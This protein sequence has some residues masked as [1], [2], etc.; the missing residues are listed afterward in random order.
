M[1]NLALAPVWCGLHINDGGISA[2][3]NLQPTSTKHSGRGRNER[4]GGIL[5]AHMDNSSRRGV[6][7][8]HVTCGE[9]GK[10][11]VSGQV[12]CRT[13]DYTFEKKKKMGWGFGG[14]VGI[15]Q[16]GRQTVN[17]VSTNSIYFW[18][19]L[20]SYRKC[21]EAASRSTAMWFGAELCIVF[22]HQQKMFLKLAA[23]QTI[24]WVLT[25][26]KNMRD[27]RHEDNFKLLLLLLFFKQYN[28]PNIH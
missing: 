28:P 17:V 18:L 9:R 6:G 26:F 27:Y 23:H 22:C 20:S 1:L 4:H 14:W 10:W 16:Q 8:I 11:R 25:G 24:N 5:S 21:F 2:E 12:S 7:V 15:S 13:F 3:R 19:Q